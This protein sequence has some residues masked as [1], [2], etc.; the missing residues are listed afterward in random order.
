MTPDGRRPHRL[1]GVLLVALTQ[2]MPTAV[3]LA[4]AAVR[5]GAFAGMGW[6]VLRWRRSA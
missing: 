6:A 4:A 1:S 3:G 2:T 5:D